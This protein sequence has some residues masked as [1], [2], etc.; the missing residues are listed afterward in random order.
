MTAQQHPLLPLLAECADVA[1]LAAA[2]GGRLNVDGAIALLTLAEHRR[3]AAALERVA[4][5]LEGMTE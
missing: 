5:A 1:T 2:N 4:E 3:I